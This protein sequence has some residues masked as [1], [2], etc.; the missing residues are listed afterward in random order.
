MVDWNSGSYE[1]TA[2]E[3]APAAE[4]VV[5]QAEIEPGHR[6]LDLG[7]GTGNAALLAARAGADVTGVDPSTRLLEVAKERVGQGEFIKATA[8]DLP[9]GDQSFDR[10]LS[11]FAVIFTDHPQKAAQ[12][13]VRV[14]KPAGKALITAWERT[15]GMHEALGMLGDATSKAA[16]APQRD[17][18]PWGEPE[19]VVA[20]FDNANVTVDRAT[21]SF[22][23][24]SAE[25]YVERFESRHPAGMLFKDVLTR[26][27]SYEEVRAQAVAAIERHNQS[28][29]ALRVTSSYLV[30]TVE[31]RAAG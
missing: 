16:Q 4:H 22:D 24:P 7:T 11:L 10:V 27:G 14:L 3:L 26:A 29:T 5:Q 18:F 25:A 6:V 15:G 23:A 12:E 19:R 28:D 31:P 9:F 30:F 21:I 8:E 17:R 20:L 13:I 1:D 2:T